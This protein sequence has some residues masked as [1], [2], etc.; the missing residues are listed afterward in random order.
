MN[1]Q[2]NDDEWL[3][4]RSSRFTLEEWIHRIGE[5][6][7]PMDVVVKEE[8]YVVV[9]RPAGRVDGHFT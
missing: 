4:S 9:R 8:T 3:V 2:T 1:I 7:G 5:S 6:V